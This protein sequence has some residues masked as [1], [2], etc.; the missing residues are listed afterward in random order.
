MPW[1]RGANL[2]AAAAGVLLAAGCAE[3]PGR[4]GVAPKPAAEHA[5]EPAPETASRAPESPVPSGRRVITLD[6]LMG[7]RE[8]TLRRLLGAPDFRR[9][10]PPARLVRYR[11]PA[12]L[13]DLFLYP[14]PGGDH[15]VTHV[16]ARSPDGEDRATSQCLD[17]VALRARTPKTG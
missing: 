11:T 6:S 15:R 2:F 5:A 17:A 4:T 7:A 1:K 12:C 10:D 16:E 13:L 3:T 8:E 14:D 9:L